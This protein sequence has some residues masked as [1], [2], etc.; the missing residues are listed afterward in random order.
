MLKTRYL[1][2]KQL[3]KVKENAVCKKMN[4]KGKPSLLDV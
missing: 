4:G 2:E 3:Q 1:K